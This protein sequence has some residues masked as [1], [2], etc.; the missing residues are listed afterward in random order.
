MT[1]GEQIEN[2][3]LR[4]PFAGRAATSA[5]ANFLKYAGFRDREWLVSSS[6]SCRV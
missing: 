2:E 1:R 5:A 3:A 6:I 4:L